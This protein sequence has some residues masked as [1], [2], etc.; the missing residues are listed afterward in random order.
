M[1]R[2]RSL[3]LPRLGK[4]RPSDV[5]AGLV[6]GLFSIPEGMAYAAIGGFNPVAGI[7]AGVVPTVVGSLFSR[8]VLMVTTLTSAL[9]LT[10]QSVLKEAGL[11]A[12]D[13]GNIAS[14]N[15]GWPDVSDGFQPLS[16]TGARSRSSNRRTW[17]AAPPG[18]EIQG[19]DRSPVH[20]QVGGGL[21]ERTDPAGDLF[22][23]EGCSLDDVLFPGLDVRV[24]G[25]EPGRCTPL[26]N[27]IGKSV[28]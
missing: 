6:T 24:P 14:L 10:S 19:S 22:G 7:Y 3:R 23:M 2:R 18:E 11:D 9:A 17:C 25:P 26:T 20:A 21:R 13:T 28:L 5:S 12:K 27:A 8:S 15:R 1:T 4:P 16:A